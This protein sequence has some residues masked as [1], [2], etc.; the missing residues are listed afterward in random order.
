[1][2][3]DDL[4]SELLY[5]GECTTVDYK[6]QQY[7]FSHAD[8]DQKSELL[9]DI[10]AFANAWRSE[11]AYILIGVKD[12]TGELV[13]LDVDIDDSRLQEYVGKKTNHPVVFSYRSLDY[14]GVKLGLYSIPVQDRPI[15]VKKKCGRVLPNAVYVR[16][17][18]STD[19]AD[20]TE[21]AKMGAAAISSKAV[22]SPR[23]V[24]KVVLPGS[25][26]SD[27]FLMNYTQWS[28]LP[29]SKYKDYL[30]DEE[31]GVIHRL[32]VAMVNK[33]FYREA[34]SYQQEKAGMVPFLLEVGNFGDQFADD[35]KISLTIP[36]APLFSF[37]DSYHL[38]K[39]PEKVNSLTHR[40]V[41]PPH[42]NGF[43][44]KYS[45]SKSGSDFLLKFNIGKLQAGEV[46]RT[47]QIFM[48]NP[49]SSLVMLSGRI[50]SD[51]LRSPVVFDI[52]AKINVS[53]ELLTMEKLKMLC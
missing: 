33:N 21:I 18:S 4:I 27:E 31:P 16:R 51:Q 40:Y 39:S 23:L 52:P 42:L 26:V 29:L 36:T 14:R 46:R 30:L 44:P 19:I 48:I 34:A 53:S 2:N 50:L 24:V 38:L 47:P 22:H 10:L 28:L 17:G 13:G 45:I 49:P 8:D 6:V 1:M 15:Y 32:M 7:P 9:K 12:G 37:K 3:D 41:E 43:G 25:I 35:V 20:P 11:M 5:R